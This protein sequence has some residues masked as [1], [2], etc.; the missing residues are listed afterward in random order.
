MCLILF[1]YQTHPEYSLIVAAN[2][3]E[4]YS[5]PSQ[6]ATFWSDAPQVIAGRDI[7][8]GG[9][10]L[11]VTRQG[12]FAALTNFRNPAR[13]RENAL[14]RGHLTANFLKCRLSPT[15]YIASIQSDSAK[16]NGFNL[17]LGEGMGLWHYSNQTRETTRIAT[18]IHGL[19]NH[20]LDT[21]WPKV[22]RGKKRL[23]Q[24]LSDPMQES[25]LFSLLQDDER[26]ADS[27]LPNTGVGLEW[28]R[29]LAPMFIASDNYGTR[30]M[31]VVTF[32]QDGLVR[33][34]ERSRNQ[35]GQWKDSSFQFTIN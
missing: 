28:E 9:T 13:N 8:H 17:L 12:R 18:G 6:A 31:T 1:A 34:I 35:S 24:L 30:A 33:F 32:R 15:D 21:P 14:S 2:R 29:V 16:Y 4:F 27:Q 22:E 25:E 5:R 7:E 10:W 23:Q 11:G 20:L 19:S 26:P 3:D